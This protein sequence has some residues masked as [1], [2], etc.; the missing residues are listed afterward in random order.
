MRLLPLVVLATTLHLVRAE[1]PARITL[2]GQPGIYAVEQWKRDWPGC[3]FEDG[4]KHGRISLTEHDG[5][6]WLRV[7]YSVGQ[8]GPEKNGAGWRYPFGQ[9][10]AAELSYT[11]RFSPDFE[12]VKG[13]KL[14]GLAGGP[15]NVA[16]G[17]PA[18]GVNGFSARL[19]W[20]GGGRGEAYVYHVHQPTKYGESFPFPDDF[21]FPTDAPIRVR[22]RVTMNAPGKRDGTL[23]VWIAERLMVERADM[24]WRTTDRFGVDSIYFETFYGGGERDWAPTR[25]GWT[26]FGEL[27]FRL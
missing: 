4:V 24:E 21:R 7:A 13:G 1:P 12:W 19:M 16:G 20:R 10:E 5:G 11:M 25:A 22:M 14:P 23:R 6:R 3:E 2:G 18:T 26:E 8:I 17:H 9:H 27:E 15:E